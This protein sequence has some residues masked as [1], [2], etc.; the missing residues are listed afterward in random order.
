VVIEISISRE[1]AAEHPG[2]MEDCAE[3]GHRVEVFDH[4]HERPE[5][6][7]AERVTGTMCP[8]R[9]TSAGPALGRSTSSDRTDRPL[10]A[11]RR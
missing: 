5:S 3:R 10:S 2:F 7:D 6:G 1:L 8:M 11:I 9:A 4:G